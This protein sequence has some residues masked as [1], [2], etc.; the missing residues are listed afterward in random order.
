V[1]DDLASSIAD[2]EQ[3]VRRQLAGSVDAGIDRAK[4]LEL[5]AWKRQA[6]QRA[7][8]LAQQMSEGD[9]GLAHRDRAH[10]A[11]V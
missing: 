4:R 5:S 7:R 9:V 11:R 2:P 3:V 8:K 10:S 1:Y 6:Q